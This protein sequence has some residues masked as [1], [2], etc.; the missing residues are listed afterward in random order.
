MIAGRVS[1]DVVASISS[2]SL[3]PRGLQFLGQMFGA[4]FEGCYS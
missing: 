4:R 3:Q 2:G 1:R